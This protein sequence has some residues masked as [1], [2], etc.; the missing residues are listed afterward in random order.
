MPTGVTAQ[1]VG[2]AG[3]DADDPLQRHHE[4]LAVADLVG[5]RPVAERV[6][7]RL[8]ELV[9]DGDLE[10][11]LLGESHLHGRPAVGLDPV[12]LAAVPLDAAHRVAAHLG[13]I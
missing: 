3:A 13:A 7:R 4:D 6:D 12:E 11:D 8:D 10:A 2:L 9:R 5:A 1:V